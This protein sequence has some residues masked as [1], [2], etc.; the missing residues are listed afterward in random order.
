ME[1]SGEMARGGL[2]GLAALIG[3]GRLWASR[4]RR[5]RRRHQGWALHAALLCRRPWP[6]VKPGQRALGGWLFRNTIECSRAQ[7]G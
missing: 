5:G 6:T 1:G 7:M 3:G 2:G 4:S